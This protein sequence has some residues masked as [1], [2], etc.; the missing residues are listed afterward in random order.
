MLPSS[1]NE[2]SAGSILV[3]R[4]FHLGNHKSGWVNNGIEE[5][6][7]HQDIG[8]TLVQMESGKVSPTI[9]VRDNP[10][11]RANTSAASSPQMDRAKEILITLYKRMVL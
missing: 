7:S 3:I 6:R 9:V 5:I 10:S 8:L 1:R 2:G 11:E 4:E